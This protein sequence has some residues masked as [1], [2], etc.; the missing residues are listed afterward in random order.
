MRGTMESAEELRSQSC[1]AEKNENGDD[2]V[3][4]K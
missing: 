2:G 1:H 4:S 3:L